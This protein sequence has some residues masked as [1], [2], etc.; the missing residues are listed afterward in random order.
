MESLSLSYP[1]DPSM[2]A[3]LYFLH[4]RLGELPAAKLE[5]LREDALSGFAK[6]E[7]WQRR[8]REFHISAFLDGE[9]PATDP[10]VRA[11][12]RPAL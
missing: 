9:V 7:Y 2:V 10:R 3:L 1:G 11:Y 6:S 12:M 5:R 4:R 8:D